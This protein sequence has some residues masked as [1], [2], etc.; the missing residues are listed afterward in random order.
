MAMLGIQFGW[1]LQMANMSAIYESLGA[2]PE[3]IG[4]LWL[5]APMSG[6]LVQPVVGALSDGTWG[7]LGRR[8]PYIL[9][10]GIMSSLGLY[11]MPSAGSVMY[12][13]L[14]LWIVDV[15]INVSME[16]MRALVADTLKE[17]ERT[18]GYVMQSVM[19]GLGACLSSGLPY[20]LSRLGVSGSRGGIPVT[21][22]YSYQI[23]AIVFLVAVLWTVVSSQESAPVKQ[24]HRH[25][26]QEIITALSNMPKTMKRLAVVQ[27]CTWLG[28]FCM[29]L[30]F[31]IAIARHVFGAS[32]TT[33]AEYRAGVEWG[34]VC[35]GVY[36]IVCF[37]VAFLLPQAARLTSHKTVHSIALGLGGVRISFSLLDRK[38]IPASF[39]YG[40]SRD[41][42][43]IDFVYAVRYAVECAACRPY[44][45]V[46]GGLQFFYS[47]S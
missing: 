25:I 22:K 17:E 23:G 13:A 31:G 43:G 40:R 3:E 21:V 45:S 8:R 24:S 16:P 37:L 10:G 39:V 30:F 32:D 35:F 4:L 19:I 42:L 14:L 29:W 5:A 36:S 20:I 1:G 7:V 18:A 11:M 46:L 27:M 34:G 47:H 26:W 44:G 2:K 6:L 41:S 15:S 28:L 12:A 38:S 33:S 9:L